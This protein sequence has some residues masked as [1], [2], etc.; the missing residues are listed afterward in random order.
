M[1]RFFAA[2]MIAVL[3]WSGDAWAT[4]YIV[5]QGITTTTTTPQITIKPTTSTGDAVIQQSFQVNL[6]GTGSIS[7]SVQIM[8]SNDGVNW[9]NYGSVI[10]VS[11]TGSVGSTVSGGG[12][13]TTSYAYFG[14]TVTA[15]S[16][17][18]TSV[19]VLL[20]A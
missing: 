18:G 6:T 8:A 3:L 14:A 19:T 9:V 4:S 1:K 5:C 11:G 17:T 15:I 2:L 7:A 13:G 10:A 16:G 20:G 12:S